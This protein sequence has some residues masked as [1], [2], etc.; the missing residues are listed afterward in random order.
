MTSALTT[1]AVEISTP[2]PGGPVRRINDTVLATTPLRRYCADPNLAIFEGRYFLYCTDDGVDGWG[3]TAFSVYASDDL[4][5][6]ERYPALDLNDVPWWRDRNGGWAPT[7]T[8]AEDG[9]YVM[10]FVADSQI[11]AAVADTPYGPFVPVAEPL[12]RRGDFDCHTIDPGVFVDYD[13]TS[14]MLWGN[15]R[16]YMA[17]FSPDR[18][19][20]DRSRVRS[21]VPGDFREAIWLHRRGGV[22]YASWSENDTRD[23]EYCVKYAMAP[24]LDGPWSEPRTLV[25]QDPGHGIY[26]TGHHN[27]VNIPGTDEWIIAYHRFAYRPDGGLRGDGGCRSDDDGGVPNGGDC[28]SD[29]GDCCSDG[30]SRAS[31]D[32]RCG[33]NGNDGCGLSDARRCGPVGDERMADDG[34]CRSGDDGRWPGDDGCRSGGD[35]RRPSSDGRWPS[36]DGRQPSG[37][38]RWSS[39]D[40]RRFDGDGCRPGG[41]GRWSGGDGCHREIVFAPLIHRADGSLEPV[42]PQV[43]SYIRPLSF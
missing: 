3:S 29:G 13:G 6:W 4:A 11:G 27:I 32:D 2:P 24:S 41:D 38:R 37:G 30:G 22:Y 35:G 43:G 21:W 14:Y 33:P 5:T 23:P 42:H 39:S 10:V 12:I 25:E 7:V 34:G 9:S 26:A 19:S 31:N 28:C 15:G 18:L 8:R 20:F 1:P 36:G 17:P 40:G 16:A